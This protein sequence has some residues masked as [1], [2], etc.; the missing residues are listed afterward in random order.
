[1][2]I[3]GSLPQ[4]LPRLLPDAL[5]NEGGGRVGEASAAEEMRVRGA[6]QAVTDRGA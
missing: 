5:P 6:R 2:L 4:V 3:L 1:M